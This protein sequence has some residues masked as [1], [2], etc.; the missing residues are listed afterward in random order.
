ME[1]LCSS[2]FNNQYCNNRNKNRSRRE[3]HFKFDVIDWLSNIQSPFEEKKKIVEVKFKNDRKEFFLYFEKIPLYQGDPVTVETVEST[4]NK[5]PIEYDVGIVNLTGELVKLQ[6]RNKNISLDSLTKK[7]YRKSTNKEI[8]IW[9]YS[10]KKEYKS[11][12]QARKFAKDLNLTMKICDVEYQGDG[13]KA[14]LYY[15]AV[16]R[17]DFRKLIKELAKTFRT[18]IEMRQIGYRQEAAKIGGIGSCGRELCC[19]TWLKKLKTVNT[20]S[21][22]YQQLSINI[23]KLTGQCSKLKCCLNYELDT[24]LSAIKDFPDIHSK[25]YTEK[26]A[27]Q[28]MKIDVFKKKMWFS[29]IKNPNTWYIIELKKIKDILKKNKKNKIAPPLEKLSTINAIQNTKLT[30]K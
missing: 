26:G 21:A 16:N 5:K 15:T 7:I 4:N 19:S 20:N 17:V 23:Q 2:C 10:K 22:R 13:K 9:N 6:I 27:A 1:K 28:C 24:Y 3:N 29:Y 8:N 11:L 18:R 25:I 12:L 30:Y 14:T